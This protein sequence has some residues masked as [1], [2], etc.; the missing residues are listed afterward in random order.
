MSRNDKLYWWEELEEAETGNLP[1]GTSKRGRPLALWPDCS[2]WRQRFELEDGI[3]VFAS[4]WFDRPDRNRYSAQP[5]FTGDPDIGFYLDGACAQNSVLATPG[6]CPPYLSRKKPGSSVLFHPWRDWGTP[7][8]PRDFRQALKW[9]LGELKTGAVVDIGCMGGHGRTG[10]ALACLL[11][12][13]GLTANDAAKWVRTRYCSEA[14][15][16]QAQ[17]RFLTTFSRRRPQRG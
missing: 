7:E 13:Q 2:H 1:Q 16:S 14:I 12:L 3:A 9:I 8:R 4:A 17:M 15:E 10:S 5:G 6:F 11:I